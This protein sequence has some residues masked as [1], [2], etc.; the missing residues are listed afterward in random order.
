M[1]RSPA[2]ASLSRDHHVALVV[3]RELIRAGPDQAEAA[4][5]RF[6]QFLAEHELAHFAIEESVLLPALPNDGPARSLAA[7]VRGDHEY[8]RAAMRRL[9]SARQPTVLG[10]LHEVGARLRAHVQMEEHELFPLIEQS[11]EPAVLERIAA[12]LAREHHGNVPRTDRH[13][14][15]TNRPAVSYPPVPTGPRCE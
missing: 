1:R 12:E 5:S 14:G 4:R 7:R 3:A 6:V 11:L 10:S 15:L 9:R 2:L 13:F 8:L